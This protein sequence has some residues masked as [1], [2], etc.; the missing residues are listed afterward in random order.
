[1]DVVGFFF[2]CAAL[3]QHKLKID[4]RRSHLS[5]HEAKPFQNAAGL[6]KFTQCEE[7]PCSGQ[8]GQTETEQILHS[9]NS[10]LLPDTLA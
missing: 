6:C 3:M 9:A 8:V 10:Y 2:T 4:Q 5:L 7:R 1:M